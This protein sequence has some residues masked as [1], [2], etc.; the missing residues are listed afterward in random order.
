[1]FPTY[2]ISVITCQ[3]DR[4]STL[5][6]YQPSQN[7]AHSCNLDSVARYSANRVDYYRRIVC[8]LGLL[9]FHMG[10]HVVWAD[11]P[12][13]TPEFPNIVLILADDLGYSD[14][15]SYGGEI[16]TPNLD[17]LAANG[18]RFTNF[19]NAA[20]C[21][22]SR[23]TLI[24]G[25]YHHQTVG[26][27][28]D[29]EQLMAAK[30]HVTIAEA[31]RRGGYRTMISGKWGMI[32]SPL[33]RGFDRFFGFGLNS[34]DYFTGEALG[35]S[36]QNEMNLDRNKFEIPESGYY[37]T[38]AITNHAIQFVDEAIAL[39]KPFFL[40][41][42]HY[43]PHF[44]L[45]APKENIDK[46]RGKYLVGWDRLREE[47]LK[48]MRELGVVDPAWSLSPRESKVP[49]W[50]SLSPSEQQEQDLLM[51]VYA[52]MVDRMD[53]NIGRLIA[54]LDNRGLTHNTLIIFLSDNG[55]NDF[56][57]DFTPNLEPGP[58]G[59]HR[60]YVHWYN[61][62]NTPFR[63]HKRVVNEGGISSPAIA[64]W[65]AGIN[66]SGD[67]VGTVA[68]FVDLMPTLLD[69][70]GVAY[71]VMYNGYKVLPMEGLSF[72]PVLTGEGH[73][74]IEEPLFWEHKGSRAVRVGSYKLVAT[75]SKTPWTL[76]DMQADRVELINMIEA[77]S[78]RATTMRTLFNMWSDRVGVP[79]QD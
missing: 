47:R 22:Q 3:I 46:Y 55:A 5:P 65:P 24:S 30:N 77:D 54:H 48:R 56:A 35:K 64:H 27:F 4:C 69:V 42:N 31:L 8:F 6:S 20:K 49:R 66:R 78:D 7:A 40:F 60:S 28:Q 43:A 2:V 53:Q 52:A 74:R 1:M 19:Y 14:L 59:H 68:H 73:A 41:L 37:L 39:E 18:L 44:P 11:Q 63:R 71:P 16:E 17:R 61:L 79:R 51:A 76:H 32:Q 58:A 29:K 21:Q 72:K 38:D 26:N 67:I 25:L 10:S 62:S 33:D 9:L 12:L 13:A 57:W 15:G 75:G 36:G 23:A 50:D 70:A 45:Q 34:V